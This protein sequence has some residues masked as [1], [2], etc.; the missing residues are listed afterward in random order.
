MAGSDLCPLPQGA[1]DD[2]AAR[3]GTALRGEH[4]GTGLRV[5]MACALFNGGITMR[6]I[7]GALDALEEAGTDRSDIS[8]AWA[9]GAFELPLVARAFA[10]AGKVDTVLCFGAVVRGDTGHYDLVAGGCATGIQ[11][12]QL[13]TG[14]PVVFGVLTTETL[15]QALERSEPDETNKGREAA[16]TGIEMVRLLRSAP[17]T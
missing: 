4:N 1:L 5:G 14:V 17:F 12:V 8:V 15:A 13:S 2:V 6:L 3:V 7:Q 11:D 9:P 16:L 10:L